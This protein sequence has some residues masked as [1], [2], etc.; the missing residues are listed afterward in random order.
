MTAPN[1]LKSRTPAHIM[2][3]ITHMHATAQRAHMRNTGHM[4]SNPRHTQQRS[5]ATATVSY[6]AGPPCLPCR[7]GAAAMSPPRS[8]DAIKVEA[9]GG[10]AC[11]YGE[12]S[13]LRTSEALRSLAT[14]ILSACINLAG[15]S[16]FG[17][18]RPSYQLP[19]PYAAMMMNI[20]E[21][22]GK[23][24]SCVNMLNVHMSQL[25]RTI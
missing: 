20:P 2:P 9:A 21:Y 14:F 24:M 13:H 15:Q 1:V 16:H 25:Q 3:L 10:A 19:S 11:M 8:P 7:C 5:N 4:P 18:P 12:R 22:N 6:G 23:Y 17:A